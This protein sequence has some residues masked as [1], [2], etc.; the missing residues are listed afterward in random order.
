MGF[1]AS[2]ETQT[3]AELRQSAVAKGIPIENLEPEAQKRLRLHLRPGA[4]PDELWELHMG[5]KPRIWGRLQQALFE[6][7]F[8]DPDHEVCPS[9]KRHT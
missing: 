3:W 4:I 8:W 2:I 5:G 6:V 9:P 7:L 1:L